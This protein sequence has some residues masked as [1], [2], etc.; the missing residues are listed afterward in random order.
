MAY[1]IN[2]LG[3]N[4]LQGGCLYRLSYQWH[5]YNGH[6][7]TN[8]FLTGLRNKPL[9]TCQLLAVVFWKLMVG[10]E[11]HFAIVC[12]AIIWWIWSQLKMPKH[13]FLW[14]FTTITYVPTHI[15]MYTHS[16]ASIHMYVPISI[17]MNLVINRTLM[18]MCT[19]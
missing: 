15:R 14:L 6:P 4:F 7:R 11:K 10:E 3:G 18:Y 19:T 8:K 2:Q 5:M 9:Y 1:E 12:V 13:T 17:G 16:I